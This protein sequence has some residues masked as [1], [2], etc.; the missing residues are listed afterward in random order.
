MV[1]PTSAAAMELAVMRI[2]ALQDDRPGVE[3]CEGGGVGAA[4]AS[5]A[6][7]RATMRAFAPWVN[8]AGDG[9]V[10]GGGGGGGVVTTPA[11]ASAS[12][13]SLA[14]LLAFHL[15]LHQHPSWEHADDLELMN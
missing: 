2:F 9:R 4:A 3:R 7:G 13:V 5:A 15:A 6:M 11:A 14:M 10:G 8:R 12:A 1:A